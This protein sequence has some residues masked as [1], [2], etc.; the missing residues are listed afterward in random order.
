MR[1][2]VPLP[3]ALLLAF[4]PSAALAA[5][6]QVPLSG[7]V[8]G[9]N[10][11]NSGLKDPSYGFAYVDG[12]CTAPAGDSMLIMSIIPDTSTGTHGTGK[13][14][15][16]VVVDDATTT[17]GGFLKDNPQLIN[18]NWSVAPGATLHVKSNMTDVTVSGFAFTRSAVTFVT[19]NCQQNP[20]NNPW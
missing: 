14:S 11:H 13:D 8:H 19:L 9:V 6:T 18:L 20:G 1:V 4:N 5:V 10:A 3:L 16:F 7:A 15:P 12:K 17:Y 2:F